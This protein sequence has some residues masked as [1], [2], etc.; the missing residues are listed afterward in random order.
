MVNRVTLPPGRRR[1]SPSRAVAPPPA[2][3]S[4]IK[5]RKRGCTKPRFPSPLA[6]RLHR[7]PISSPSSDVAAPSPFCFPCG[8]VAAARTSRGQSCES[9]SFCV[10]GGR[11]VAEVELGS[12]RRR[13]RRPVQ[14]RDSAVGPTIGGSAGP[15]VGRGSGAARGHRPEQRRTELMQRSVG[16]PAAREVAWANKN[17]GYSSRSGALPRGGE[18]AGQNPECVGKKIRWDDN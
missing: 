6:A 15:L 14:A 18:L 7:A 8:G 5:V 9:N 17:L 11:A 3:Q 16:P 12:A 2:R 4:W 1:G 10:Y 13:S